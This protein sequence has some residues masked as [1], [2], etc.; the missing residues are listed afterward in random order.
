MNRDK[1]CAV[2]LNRTDL[3]ARAKAKLSQ[4]DNHQAFLKCEWYRYAVLFRLNKQYQERL[5][6]AKWAHRVP[7]MASSIFV[8]RKEFRLRM[9]INSQKQPHCGNLI[10]TY[11]FGTRHS[12]L[13]MLAHRLQRVEKTEV[14]MPWR[15]LHEARSQFSD[16][17]F[18]VTFKHIPFTN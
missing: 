16:A 17:H 5:F 4:S 12:R 3:I 10:G 9:P 14:G 13:L 15:K 18:T 11:I 2:T 7:C 8:A 1:P 6:R